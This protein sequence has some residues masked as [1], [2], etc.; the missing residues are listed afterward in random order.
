MTEQTLEALQRETLYLRQRNA[1][2][3]AD[4]ADLAAEVDRLRQQLERLHGR[5]PQRSPNPLG[6]G[7]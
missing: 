6:G 1:Q 7:Q 2:L 5:A 4:V 3:Q